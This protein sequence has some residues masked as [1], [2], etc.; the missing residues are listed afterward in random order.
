MDRRS[1]PHT[2]GSVIN[3]DSTTK[4]RGRGP[5]Q[6]KNVGPYYIDVRWKGY[7]RIQTSTGTTKK[8]R[9]EAMLK[10]VHGLRDLGRRDL[11]EA[12]ASRKLTLE[13]VHELF[14]RHRMDELEQRLQRSGAEKLGDLV[15]EWLD[16]LRSP[17]ALAPRTRR[18][19]APK[20]VARYEQSW[21]NFLKHLPEGRSASVHALTK[22]FVLDFR[23]ERMKEHVKGATVNRD[24]IALRS[25]WHWLGE[26]RGIAVDRFKPAMEREPSGSERWLD[27][28]EIARLREHSPAGWWTLFATLLYTGIRVGEAQALRW[29]DIKGAPSQI[30]I[31]GRWRRLKTSGSERMVGVTAQLAAVLNL[32]RQSVPSGPADPVFPGEYGDYQ[33]AYRVFKRAVKA[34]GL[35]P[36]RVHDLRHTFGVHA[37]QAGVPITR[38][39]ALLGHSSPMVTMRYMRHDPH[40]YGASDVALIAARMDGAERPALSLV[41]VEKPVPR[42]TA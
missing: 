23:K 19:Y 1:Y 20:T 24:M 40:G 12:V 31:H 7:P 27:H 5:Y 28:D 38:I 18:P 3:M 29:A 11:L 30:A 17:G 42:R 32:H 22:G 2:K 34:A 33:R 8:R 6:H 39:Q 37:A 36:T 26:H 14:S 16:W 35:E 15:D 25:F 41:A 9:A 4:Q 10:T 13:E 21:A